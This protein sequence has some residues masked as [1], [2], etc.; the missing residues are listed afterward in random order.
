MEVH[1]EPLHR[2]LMQ[3]MLALGDYK[4]TIET[5]ERMCQKIEEELGEKPEPETVALYRVA[6]QT[7]QKNQLPI[8][9]IQEYLS[10]SK[11]EGAL[12]CDYD[13]F[14]VLCHTEARALGRNDIP[15]HIALISMGED[16]SAKAVEL[17]GEQI[18]QTLRQSDAFARCSTSQYIVM[19]PQ[20]GLEN[21]CKV[22][23][24]ILDAYHRQYPEVHANIRYQVKPLVSINNDR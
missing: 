9:E 23:E 10:E 1:H 13:Y 19:L 3:A 18:R 20:A 8:E 11:V 17:L 12:Q 22:C 14:K 21:S 16:V 4:G 6:L 24:R 2:S 5:Y 7:L 15:T